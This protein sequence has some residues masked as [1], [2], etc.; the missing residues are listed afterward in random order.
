LADLAT[1]IPFGLVIFYAA[2]RIMRV[3]ELDLAT[4]S[5]AGPILRRVWK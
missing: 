3:T 1:S 4:R 2:C 5:L